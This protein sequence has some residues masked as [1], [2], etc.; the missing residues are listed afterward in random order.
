[1]PRRW[2]N[3]AAAAAVCAVVAASWYSRSGPVALHYLT[4]IAYVQE[5]SS[6]L[7]IEHWTRRGLQAIH[8]LA[9][10]L[11]IVLLP[12]LAVGTWRVAGH[13]QSRTEGGSFVALLALLTL[14]YLALSTSTDLGIGFLVPL[15]PVLVV[16]AV[17]AAARMQNRTARAVIGSVLIASAAVGLI[18]KSD[19]GLPVPRRASVRL[20]AV[21]IVPLWQRDDGTLLAVAALTS[22][23][24][25]DAPAWRTA[26]HEAAIAIEAAAPRTAARLP[27]WTTSTADLLNYNTM[28]MEARYQ[29]GQDLTVWPLELSGNSA[30]AMRDAVV[31]L[32]YPS[33]LATGEGEGIG[34]SSAAG[35]AADVLRA[36]NYS[37]V[38]VIPSP[39]HGAVTVWRA[40]QAQGRSPG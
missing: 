2:L 36:L 22:D 39:D 31:A 38:A 3:A 18:S 30:G 19:L 15:Y 13:R 5:P 16:C 24:L 11:A 26:S 8:E 1:M 40:S 12:L 14:G 34:A 21:G 4:S 27:A 25:R 9:L 28:M 32:G 29:D 37:I 35:S 6:P 7:R 10:P 23:G 17:A 20:P 33:V